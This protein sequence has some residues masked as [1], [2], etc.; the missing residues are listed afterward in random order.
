[1]NYMITPL[2]S[3]G[4]LEW[5]MTSDEVTKIIG[6]P[7]RTRR[8]NLKDTVQ[9][10]YGGSASFIFDGISGGLVEVTGSKSPTEFQIGSIKL[11]SGENQ[12]TVKQ[13]LALDRRAFEGYGS[14]IFPDLGIMLTGYSP[15]D[16]DIRAAGVFAPGRC[17][18]ILDSMKPF[19]ALKQN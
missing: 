1:V 15:E 8:N 3:C 4:P 12:E 17:D 5:G 11:I 13:L 19:R 9:V 2:I 14:L 16:N 6:P 10:R 18:D 7:E